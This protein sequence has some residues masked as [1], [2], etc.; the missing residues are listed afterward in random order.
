MST[1]YHFRKSQRVAHLSSYS[2]WGIIIT[3]KPGRASPGCSWA[4]SLWRTSLP[5]RWRECGEDLLGASVLPGKKPSHSPPCLM[6]VSGRLVYHSSPWSSERPRR[7][8]LEARES[9][10]CLVCKADAH[11]TE[12]VYHSE[13]MAFTFTQT[14]KESHTGVPSLH[15]VK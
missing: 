14:L 7:C 8:Y 2:S 10:W 9:V 4:G 5:G 11:L 12:S 1:I 6:G 3:I 13:P 15:Y